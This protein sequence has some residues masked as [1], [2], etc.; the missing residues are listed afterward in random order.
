MKIK[1]NINPFAEPLT[2]FD[3]KKVILKQ[4]KKNKSI[5]YGATAIKKHIGFLARDTQ[6]VDVIAKNPKKS[7]KQLE[8]SLDKMAAGDFYYVKPAMH[9]GTFK[10]KHKGMD[11]RMNTDDDIEIADFTKPSRKVKTKMFG[12]IKYVALPEIIKDKRKSLAD[13]EY[14]FRHEKDMDDLQRIKLARSLKI[15]RR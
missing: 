6:D 12:G 10:V 4:V 8:K 3:R 11:K 2:Y 7:A 1:L 9:P 5:V 13:K 14:A 15:F